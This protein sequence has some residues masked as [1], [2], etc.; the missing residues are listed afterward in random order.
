MDVRRAGG[1]I[2]GYLE[3]LRPRRGRAR[4]TN[5]LL[6]AR[7]VA[8][9]VGGALVA[10]GAVLL[11]QGLAGWQEVV[12]QSVDP[13]LFATEDRGTRE[14]LA[15]LSD[16]DER[17]SPV[18]GKMLFVF[19][20]GV[21]VFAGFLLL[22]HIM[23][24]VVDTGSEGRWAFGGHQWIRIAVAVVLMAPMPGGASGAQ[25]IVLGLAR[26][27]GDFANLVWEPLAGEAL[28][29]GR[30]VV[31][32]PREAAWR[33]VIARMLVSEV[34]MYVANEH[35]RGA[36]DEAYVRI[37]ESLEHRGEEGWVEDQKE[38]EVGR[39]ALGEDWFAARKESGEETGEVRHYDGVDRGMQG[40]MCGLVRFTGLEQD[41]VRGI[42]ARGHMAAWKAVHP[43][44]VRLARELGD[45]FVPGRAGYADPL[46]DMT[47]ELDAV[48]AARTYRAVLEERVKRAGTAAQHSLEEAIREDA[49]NINWLAAASFVNT[50]SKSAG[51]VQAASKN[52]P[53]AS[54]PSPDLQK[55]SEPAA[56]AVQAVMRGLS[57]A[58]GY[59]AVPFAMATGI[60]GALAPS[61]GRGGTVLDRVTDF[62]DPKSVIMA[63]SGNP[64]LDLTATG[65]GLMN[66][67]ILAMTL[68]AGVSVGS[69][70]LGVVESLDAFQAGWEVMDGLVTP[71]IGMMII[72]GAVLA[73]VLPAIP[74]IRF[75]FGIL[76]WL[77]AVVEAMLAVTVFCAAHVQR[78]EGNW[79]VLPETRAGW[80]FL[81]GLVLRPV[82]MLF[83]LVIGYFVFI[84]VME[85]FNEI[86]VPRMLDANASSGLDLIDF[87]AMLALYVMVAYGLLNA[88]FKLID[89]LPSAVLTWIGGAGSGD[90]GSEGVMG[91]AT[92]GFGRAAALGGNRGFG[93]R[94]GGAGAAGGG[95]PSRGS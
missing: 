52:V 13:G 43:A 41:G 87:V 48:G 61:V 84:T 47:A 66:T 88:C 81:P 42:A 24:A 57:Q 77:L 68:L 44:V 30:A 22:W 6:P 60:A 38:K 45:H 10:G 4:L 31:P 1:R 32:W 83:G 28:G 69:N 8:A 91:M 26:L 34:C 70:F 9:I 19:N 18:L 59:E 3:M 90:S 55:W 78:A 94:G 7:R 93:P 33:T 89:V 56:S 64:L 25:L 50:L 71:A 17:D 21:M 16:F 72:A 36:G 65:Y 2:A 67:G 75:L 37:R 86:W 58:R 79:F 74:F 85:I 11:V 49:E 80:L 27:G 12:A 29:K 54:L 15:F 51:R 92:G 5:Y 40:D 82:L 14:L 95:A 53:E 46:P 35:A 39:G 23:T 73:Y 76:A 20:A 62:I 63:D